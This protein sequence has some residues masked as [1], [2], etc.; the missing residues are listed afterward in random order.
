M[1]D[2]V[3]QVRDLT[4]ELEKAEETV[5]AVRLKRRLL[6][7]EALESGVTSSS[8][9]EPSRMSRQ[10]I[11]KDAKRADLVLEETTG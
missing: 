11:V 7:R 3:K 8:L 9:E 4:D 6:L 2:Y 10:A 1:T 5:T